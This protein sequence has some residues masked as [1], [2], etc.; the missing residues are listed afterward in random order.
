MDTEIRAQPTNPRRRVLAVVLG[1]IALLLMAGGAQLALL[2]GSIYYLAAGV[3]V[4]ATAWLAFKGDWREA[5][6]YAAFLAATLVWAV[7]ESGADI[8]ALQS[9]LVAP[10]V[11]GLWVFWPWLK[12]YRSLSVG[13]L[14]VIVVAFG[15]WLWHKKIIST[16]DDYSALIQYRSLDN[17]KYAI[18]T[19]E[20][21]LPLLYSLGLKTKTDS[22]SFFN[23]V[24]TNGSIAMTS[25]L[26]QSV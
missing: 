4:A 18:P 21:F 17:S 10:I 1:A 19:P 6:V 25:V 9:R 13:V 16:S 7:W 12:R 23:D 24:T 11:L 15:G 5:A 14:A 20:H 8:W 22:I 3:A 26:I 2:G